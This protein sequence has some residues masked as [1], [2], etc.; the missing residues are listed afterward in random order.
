[1]KLPL[2]VG[3]GSRRYAPRTVTIDQPQNYEQVSTREG[4]SIRKP[5]AAS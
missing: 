1:M 2:F 5:R 4:L 3:H